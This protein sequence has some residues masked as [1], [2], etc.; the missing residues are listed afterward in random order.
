MKKIFYLIIFFLAILGLAG[1]ASREIVII[2]SPPVN[3]VAVNEVVNESAKSPSNHPLEKGE[4][5]PQTTPLVS[6]T[7]PQTTNTNTNSNLKT[8]PNADLFLVSSVV[9]GDTVKVNI[10]GTVETLR[11]IGIDTPET[12]DP[13]K[14]V[15]CFGVEASN[16]AKALLSGKM[17]RLEADPTQGE[18]DVYGRLL[19]YVFLSDGTNFNKL[20]IEQGYAF[21][22]TYSTP[23]KYQTEFNQAETYART[24]KLGLWADDT[25][26]GVAMP[27]ST[28]TNTNTNSNTNT[29]APEGCVIKGNIST[30]KIYH[31]PGCDSYDKTVIDESAGER[32]FCTEEEA[33]A[34]GWRKAKNCP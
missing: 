26:A 10:A 13:R 16:K 4:D 31:L 3:G 17:V 1:C 8:E 14:P 9:D 29:G 22:Y 33:M 2:N 23:Y 19:R 30:E 28:D 32:W 25:C 18:R 24:N 34:A 11:L 5:A 6:S 7:P 21:E 27:V 20:M 12:V 15:Q